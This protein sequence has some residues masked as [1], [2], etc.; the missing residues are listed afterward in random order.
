VA[1]QSPDASGEPVQSVTRLVEHP[2]PPGSF[3]KAVVESA[4]FQSDAE[5]PV[6]DRVHVGHRTPA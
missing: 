5:V 2:Q 4:Q 6:Q 3:S 1:G